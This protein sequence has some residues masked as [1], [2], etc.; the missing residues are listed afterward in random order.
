MADQQDPCELVGAFSGAIA[1]T[2][3]PF[4]RG[5]EFEIYTIPT[6]DFT[7]TGVG[8]EVTLTQLQLNTIE[9]AGRNVLLMGDGAG[10]CSFARSASGCHM[11]RSGE[12]FHHGGDS[13]I[14]HKPIA[15]PWRRHS[16]VP[17]PK[18]VALMGKRHRCSQPPTARG[19]EADSPVQFPRDNLDQE[20]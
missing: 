15:E 10:G 17:P 19:P 3:A 11:V 2:V 8:F 1:S 12:H 9:G 6:N 16:R 5:K 18:A 7:I 13:G 4:L 14:A 20:A